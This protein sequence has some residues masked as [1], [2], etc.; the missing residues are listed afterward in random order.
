MTVFKATHVINFAQGSV[1][2][3]GAYVIARLHESIGFWPAVIVGVLSAAIG[4]V[5]IDMVLIRRIRRAD[6]G[7]L[8][9]LTIGV[10]AERT[11]CL[12]T[13]A[14]SPSPFARAVRM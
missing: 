5:L 9:I 10:M 6:L 11:P 4:S 12:N 8:A 13:T 1:L 14:R 3:L 2:L 7:T